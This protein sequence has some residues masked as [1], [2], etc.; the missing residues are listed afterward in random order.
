MHANVLAVHNVYYVQH[1]F[2]LTKQAEPHLEIRVLIYHL[3]YIF[4]PRL[5][6]WKENMIFEETVISNTKFTIP[7]IFWP[8]LSVP[9]IM[10]L[11]P[12]NKKR[13]KF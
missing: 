12:E 3:I 4:S 13:D 7:E 2:L 10:F 9:K 1:V 6:G 8:I 5:F 11:V